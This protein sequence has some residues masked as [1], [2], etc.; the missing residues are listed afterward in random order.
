MKK[1]KSL[2]IDMSKSMGDDRENV[3]KLSKQLIETMKNVTGNNFKIGLGT[4]VDRPVQ[5]FTSEVPMQL[6]NPCRVKDGTCKP[7]YT[8][9]N[10]L[11]VR[12]NDIFNYIVIL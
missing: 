2:S 3:I 7:A 5:P 6:E 4:F 12:I 8:F 11:P 10:N 1:L 9:R